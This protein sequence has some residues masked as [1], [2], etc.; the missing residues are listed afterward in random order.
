MT[1]NQDKIRRWTELIETLRRIKKGANKPLYLL[2]DMV[3]Y[4]GNTALTRF[5][6]KTSTSSSLPLLMVETR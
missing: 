1:T 3:N 2:V 6:D 5:I 4:G